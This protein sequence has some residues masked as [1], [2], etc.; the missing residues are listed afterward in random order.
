MKTREKAV[1]L[2]TISGVQLSHFNSMIICFVIAGKLL[3]VLCL[4]LLTGQEGDNI[5]RV[6][7]RE[8]NENLSALI[9]PTPIAVISTEETLRKY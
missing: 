3:N 6:V 1:V 5:P 2:S 8:N 7:L 4:S 9:L